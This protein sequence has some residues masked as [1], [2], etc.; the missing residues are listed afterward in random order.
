M[1]KRLKYEKYNYSDSTIVIDLHN[2][3]SVMAISG[4]N[5]ESNLYNTT[6]LLKDN[7]YDDW[8]RMEEFDCL[9]FNAVKSTIN[10]AILKEVSTYLDNNMFDKYIERYRYKNKCC[11][12]G[13][14]HFE[15]ERNHNNS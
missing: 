2:E 15:T 11:D 9:E 5:P 6:L 12:F 10:S 4:L 7:E 14:E 1:K 8:I 13:I 3:Y